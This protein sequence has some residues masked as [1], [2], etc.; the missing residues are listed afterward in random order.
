MVEIGT[1]YKTLIHPSHKTS[2]VITPLKIVGGVG[3]GLVWSV[4]TI[5][6]SESHIRKVNGLIIKRI[7]PSI[8][9][10]YPEA[11]VESVLEKYLW[12]K[13]YGLPVVPTLRVNR[14]SQQILMTD[15]TN[16][17]RNEIIDKHNPLAISRI[18]ILNLGELKEELVGVAE[19]AYNSGDGV[20]LDRDAFAVIVDRTKNIGKVCLLDLGLGSYRLTRNELSNTSNIIY[21]PKLRAKSF[22]GNYLNYSATFT[23]DKLRVAA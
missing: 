19:R 22:I 5:I 12:L 20:I 3:E 18:P 13:S 10:D 2:A 9:G 16:G 4:G 15:M 14:D 23:P 11:S 7:N 21:S 6:C 1:F 17:G 8:I